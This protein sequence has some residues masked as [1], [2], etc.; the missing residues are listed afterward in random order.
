MQSLR[1]RS[2]TWEAEGILSFEL[3]SPQGQALPEVSAGAHLEV[4]TPAGPLRHYSLCDAPWQRSH[5]RIGVLDA[6]NGRGGSRAM[7]EQLRPGQLLEVSEPRN[8]FPLAAEA[9]HH[10]LLGGGIGLTPLLAMAEQLAR[11]GASWELHVCTRS[12]ER[13]PFRD[14]LLAAAWAGRVHLHHD[15]GDPAK[16]LDI[17]ALLLTPRPDAHVYCCGPAGFMQAATTATAHWPTGTVHFEHF[18]AAAPAIAAAAE[19]GAGA[20]S[21]PNADGLVVL[22]SSGREIRIPAGMTV[23]HALRAAGIDCLSSCEAGVCGTCETRYLEGEPVHNDHVLSDADR[24]ELVMI[25]CALPGPKPLV[26]DL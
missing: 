14:R 7:H 23:L 15:G 24:R 3:V 13:T 16:G 19:P 26:L 10:V 11:D 8:F 6:P 18:G 25:C 21:N 4:R 22:K 20:I 17:A 9:S 2:I 12:L 5:W 1:I